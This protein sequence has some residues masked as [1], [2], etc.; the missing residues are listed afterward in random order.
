MADA[1]LDVI[2]ITDLE[3]ENVVYV[4]PSFE[5]IWGRKAQDLHD[6]PHLWIEAIH[7]EDRERVGKGF[8]EW[9]STQPSVPWETEYRIVHPGG[10]IRWIIEHGVVISEVGGPK[11]VNGISKDVADHRLMASA[12]RESEERFALAVAGSN[13]VPWDWDIPSD[14]MFLSD[15]AHDAQEHALR[16]S[17]ASRHR[18]HPDGRRTRTVAGRAD[19]GLQQERR[20]Q[21]GSR[22]DRERRA[23]GSRPALA[24]GAGGTT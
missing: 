19:P 22:A 14:R 18:V 12:L 6:N 17:I 3:P 2:W 21:K 4:S 10:G 11:R 5:R 7:P 9:I 24:H 1:T 15:R 23:G 16:Q 13:D 20:L 8:G